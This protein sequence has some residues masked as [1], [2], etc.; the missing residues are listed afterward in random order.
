MSRCFMR[1]LPIKPSPDNF[2]SWDSANAFVMSEGSLTLFSYISWCIRALSLSGAI[3]STG[4]A[5]TGVWAKVVI[6]TTG[7]ASFFGAG[8]GAVVTWGVVG[9]TVLATTCFL[10]SIFGATLVTIVSAGFY[11]TTFF[12]SGIAPLLWVTASLINLLISNTYFICWTIGAGFG[13]DDIT[14]TGAGAGAE[15][16]IAYVSG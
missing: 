1:N 10:I 7:S 6:L 15:T 8:L 11:S 3:C 5:A 16:C 14:I 9:T 13:V 12:F 4:G 2:N